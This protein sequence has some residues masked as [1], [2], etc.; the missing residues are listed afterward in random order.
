MPADEFDWMF[1]FVLQ[2]LESD[3]FDAAVMDFVDEKCFLFD[4]EEENKLIYTDI[5]QEFCEHIEGLL[6]TNLFEL[7]ITNEMFVDSCEKAR[8][9][10]DINMK[11]F[12]R[13]TAMDDF[14]TFKKIMAK[15]NTE[16]Q[17]E[18]IQSFKSGPGRRGEGKDSNEDDSQHDSLLDPDALRQKFED[19]AQ[20]ASGEFSGMEEEEVIVIANY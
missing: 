13:L 9:A 10:R 18:A 3:K 4:D 12:E 17:L 19:Y 6:S 5:H 8:H 20:T 16:L 11:V 7:G 15:R 1:D 14:Q 2:F